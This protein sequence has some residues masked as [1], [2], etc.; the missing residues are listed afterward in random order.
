[1]KITT[2]D[3]FFKKHEHDL[4]QKNNPPQFQ[5]KPVIIANE[6]ARKN[7][8]ITLEEEKLMHCIF[9]QLKP[10]E[11]N[12]TKVILNKEELWEMLDL[13][14]SRRYTDIKQKL[15]TLIG[16]TLVDFRD[17]KGTDRVGYVLIDFNSDHKSPEI[18]V[19]LNPNFMPF[20][21]QLVNHY[22]KLDLNTIVQ[23]DSK[24][25]LTLYKFLSSWRTDHYHRMVIMTTK[26]LKELFGLTKEDYV[27]SS[28]SFDRYNFEK[29]TL[30]TAIDEINEK[31]PYWTVSY[32]KHKQGNRIKG[33]VIEWLERNRMKSDSQS[34]SDE[35]FQLDYEAY[36]NI[37]I[38]KGQLSLEDYEQ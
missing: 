24:F 21:E 5:E 30:E 33:Y 32:K 16:K 13:S 18:E 36:K 9:S 2:V 34:V 27:K 10:F 7:T 14:S 6:L 4:A 31:V 20:I 3:S 22:T 28:G 17:E 29:R 12:N 19:S 25:S 26:E 37:D 15:K 8:L 11:K 1:M 35:Q 23:F 38:E